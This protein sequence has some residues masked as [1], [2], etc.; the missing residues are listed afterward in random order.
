LPNLIWNTISNERLVV[1]SV[2]SWWF[3][4]AVYNRKSMDF[5]RRGR[6]ESP[7]IKCIIVFMGPFSLVRCGKY[8][9]LISISRSFVA[10]NFL[11]DPRSAL[12]ISSMHSWQQEAY[13]LWPWMAPREPYHQMQQEVSLSSLASL[14]LVLSITYQMVCSIIMKYKYNKK[15]SKKVSFITQK[16]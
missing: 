10:S 2:D 15:N 5:G 16:I 3:V 14:S 12:D 13:G 11:F 8:R 7:T 6:R 4:D 1:S 9:T